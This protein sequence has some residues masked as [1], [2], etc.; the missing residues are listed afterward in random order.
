M[1]RRF[2]LSWAALLT[3]AFRCLAANNEELL[4]QL[5]FNKNGVLDELEIKAGLKYKLS[6]GTLDITK[7]SAADI[8]GKDVEHMWFDFKLKHGAKSR[9]AF[10]E[11]DPGRD[12]GL[13]K[14][15]V[16]GSTPEEVNNRRFIEKG[17]FKVR[18]DKDDLK[19]SITDPDIQGAL[20]S[21][22]RNFNSDND[23]WIARG[24]LDYDYLIYNNQIGGTFDS[25]HLDFRLDFNRVSTGGEVTKAAPNPSFESKEINS[26]VFGTNLHLLLNGPSHG[27]PLAPGAAAVF[28]QGTI[29]DLTGEWRTDFDFQSSVPMA[30]L[31][32]APVISGIG[33]GSLYQKIPWLYFRW[34]FAVH[35]EGGKVTR[36]GAATSLPE[37]TIIGRIGPRI[38][39]DMLPFP[40]ALDRRLVLSLSFFQYEPF[41]ADARESRLF[42]A[43]ASYYFFIPTGSVEQAGPTKPKSVRDARVALTL[44][45]TNGEVPDKTPRDN[46]LILGLGVAF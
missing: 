17:E 14:V 1:K 18:R 33:M 27:D 13:R 37:D 16:A 24:I 46:T 28:Y 15:F 9:Y 41:T 25:A 20:F 34:F 30:T 44:E 45:Y 26:L 10:S 36:I 3:V 39:L 6:G 11:V 38:S 35:V 5:D 8:S 22:G 12:F 32:V 7:I 31:D 42:K 43:A 21:Y 19:K 2:L 23:Q 29:I 4:R 40:D